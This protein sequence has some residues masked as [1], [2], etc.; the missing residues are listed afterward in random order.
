MKKIAAIGELLWDIFPDGKEVGGAPANFAIISAY[1]GND[2]YVISAVG[3]DNLG[4][5]LT[6]KLKNWQVDVD[7]LQT[8]PDYKTG[9]VNI[10]INE[11]GIPA[12]EIVENRAC[13]HIIYTEKLSK[14]LQHF[15][16]ISFGSLSSRSKDTKKTIFR[17]LEQLPNSC[18]KVCD[19]NLRKNY[20]SKDLIKKLLGYS[21]VFKIND[22]ERRLLEKNLNINLNHHENYK[23][24]IIENSLKY[25]IITN[26]EKGSYIITEQEYSEQKANTVKVIDTVGAGD[27]FLAASIDGILHHKPVKI[28]HQQAVDLSAT[29]CKY[30][31]ATGFL[32]ATE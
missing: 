2:A 30:K 17:V 22:D 26:G 28:W 16:A 7:L 5:E 23:D 10:K 1:L 31:G 15:D 27:A 14:S 9:E 12:Y 11:N 18:L 3:T 24:F 13:D 6:N 20:Y 19:L 29:V 8:H 25:L 32:K 4:K 21:D